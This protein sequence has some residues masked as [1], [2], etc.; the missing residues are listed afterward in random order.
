MSKNEALF[1]V[2]TMFRTLIKGISQEWNK[3]NEYSL[4]FPQY[5]MLYIL[6]QHGTLKVSQLADMIGIT[7]SAITSLTDKLLTDGYVHRERA[8]QDRR[9][10]YISITEKGKEIAEKVREN[11][12]ETIHRIFDMLEEED[13]EHLRRIYA[14]MLSNFDKNIDNK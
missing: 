12:Q 9:V 5:K 1:E 4:S 11:Q 3:R 7:S 2:A 13:I 10:V 14:V 8:E 6:T